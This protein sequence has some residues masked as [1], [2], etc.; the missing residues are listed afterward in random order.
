MNRIVHFFKVARC[1]T[2][3]TLIEILMAA[4]ASTL[5]LAALYG[6]FGRA[7]HLRDGAVERT[8]LAHVHARVAAI[9]RND[10]RNARISGGTLADRLE[11]SR[12]GNHSSFPGY[13]KLT[14]T[15][16][17][18][19]AQD[20]VAGDIHQVEYY[21][22]S[23][24]ET[25]GHGAGILVRAIDGNLLAPIREAPQASALMAGVSSLE[26][27]FYDGQTWTD[28]WEVT[29]E[30]KTVP[31]AIRVRITQAAAE[32][33]SPAPPIEILVPW[34]TQ[35]VTVPTSSTTGTPTST[36][37]TPSAPAPADPDAEGPPR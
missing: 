14:T 35:A 19:L 27:T 17:A 23:D 13:L 4:A 22:M 32:G 16:A 29:D 5:I 24:P 31:Q 10:L 18:A 36:S 30:E 3:F 33:D 11:G 15:T 25:S 2:A 12:Q 1:R 26:V 37:G 9:I 7:M 20:E 34:T 21:I 6:V 28:T 8:R